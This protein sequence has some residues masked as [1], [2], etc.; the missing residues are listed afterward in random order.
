[1]RLFL[2]ML[3]RS[4]EWIPP[5]SV[6]SVVNASS[7]NRGS[8]LGCLCIPF[9]VENSMIGFSTRRPTVAEYE[10]FPHIVMTSDEEWD[11]RADHLQHN[12]RVAMLKTMEE[13]Q[14]RFESE[15]D[16][17]L[18]SCSSIHTSAWE[19]NLM[20]KVQVT[21]VSAI[22]SDSRN[23]VIT[24]ER[25]AQQFNIGLETARNTLKVTTQ[26]GLRSAVHPISRRYRTDLVRGMEA[27]QTPGNWYTDTL[28]STVK[29]ITG[30]TC[31]QLF[32]NQRMITTYP[33]QT[34]S[35]AG[36]ALDD[37]IE[38]VGIPNTL[39]FDNAAEQVG[40]GTKFMKTIKRAHIHWRLTEPYA[41]WQNRAEDSIR[42]VKKRWKRTKMRTGCSQRIWDFGIQH[43]ARILSRISRGKDGRTGIEVATGNTPDIS[44]DVA[45]T[46]YE[47]VL[48]ITNPRAEYNPKLG[49][50][51]GVSTRQAITGGDETA[52][53]SIQE[54][55]AKFDEEVRKVLKDDLHTIDEH[56]EYRGLLRD[57]DVEDDEIEPMEN[58]PTAQEADDHFTTDA[59]D[60]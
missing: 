56:R 17:V 34:K 15:Y 41:H 54:R 49:R 13:L 38:D 45:F 36:D 18:R 32:T 16:Q 2:D 55:I 52:D 19:E 53:N 28:F 57:I 31:C 7:C 37:F 5:T 30:N 10:N 51:L 59:F 22:K 24:A 1:M 46:F 58:E 11:P 40:P 27:K 44:E 48:Y 60:Q 14:I 35:H 21:R 33:M 43:E 47:P 9:S 4:T 29:S 39:I 25:L 12:Q 26:K 50:W 3:E 23:S 42:E 20:S 8:T 6:L